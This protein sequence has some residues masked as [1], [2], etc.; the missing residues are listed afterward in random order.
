M[1][2]VS[3]GRAQQVAGDHGAKLKL[4][5]RL[6]AAVTDIAIVIVFCPG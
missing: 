5:V 1:V 6:P 2:I 4:S 3:P